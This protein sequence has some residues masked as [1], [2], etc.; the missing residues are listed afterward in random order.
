[1]QIKDISIFWKILNSFLLISTFFYSIYISTY[2]IIDIY[3]YPKLN[4]LRRYILL[5]FFVSLIAFYYPTLFEL[6]IREGKIQTLLYNYL[7]FFVCFVLSFEGKGKHPDFKY[8]LY[9]VLVFTPAMF[10]WLSPTCHLVS[11]V[12]LITSPLIFFASLRSNFFF[13]FPLWLKE[14]YLLWPSLCWC[15]FC[16]FLLGNILSDQSLF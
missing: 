14:G 3:S 1:M 13:F 6:Y 7:L 16:L 11:W 10:E 8:R 12:E 2:L 9:N 5:S 15:P 4:Y